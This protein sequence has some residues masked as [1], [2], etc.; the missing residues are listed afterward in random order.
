MSVL[1]YVPSFAEKLGPVLSESIGNIGQG[2]AQ[3]SNKRAWEKFITPATTMA[4]AT[5][6][7]VAGVSDNLNQMQQQAQNQ[8]AQSPLDKILDK[9]GGPSLG[10]FQAI[11]NLAEKANPGSGKTV[12]DYLTNKMKSGDKEAIQIRKEN[13]AAQTDISKKAQEQNIGKRTI[14]NDQRRNL[15]LALDAVQSG[16]VG[17]FGVN[18]FADLFG[19]AGKRFKGA[20]AIQ[21]DTAT[22]GLL[23]D[24]I[25]KVSA[26]GTNLWLEKVAKT[27][28]PELGKTEEANESLIKIAMANLDIE[29]KQLDIQDELIQKYIQAGLPV[30]SNIEKLTNDILQPY[31][32]QV[33]NKLAYDTRVIYEREKGPN[34]LGSLEKVPKGT[35][36]TL[37]KRDAL[38]K[39]FG[40]DK[41]Q[42]K[43]IA[44]QL[45][46]SIPDPRVVM[47]ENQPI[48]ENVNPIQP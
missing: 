14:I 11:V 39:K 23:F 26:K 45:G 47:Q 38:L 3:R 15:N 7:N 20:K 19:E 16:D 10:E 34:F 30:P 5:Q 2:F 31:A 46:Y 29:E 22:K 36:L 6:P 43:K 33:Q 28:L 18:S 24:N 12:A 25:N 37:E 42:V 9:P 1:P 41:E 48:G 44:K 32:E 8:P 35:P 4:N 13:R 21:L 40:G 17:A 27:A